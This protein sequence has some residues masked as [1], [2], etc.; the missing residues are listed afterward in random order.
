MS[1]WFED[2]SFWKA[3]YPFM[4]SERKFDGATDEVR[5]I[6]DLASLDRGDVLDLAC[7]PGRHAV[8]L[9][10]EGFN[11]TGVDLSPF[12]LQKAMGLAQ[13]EDVDV[14][15]VLEDMRR[16]VRPE[17]F[18]LVTSI[19]TSFG[20]FDDKREDMI[21]LQNIHRS[22]REGG[23]LVM[24]LMGK[25]WLARGFLPTSSEELADGRLLVE[26]REIT[27]D[28]TRVKNQWTVIEGDRATTFRFEHTVYSGQE[29]RDRL[30][31]AGFSDVQLFGG[32]D[33]REYGLNAHRLVA[34]ARKAMKRRFL[35]G[36][37]WT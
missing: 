3:L 15:W 26:R 1:E 36:Q 34:V 35:F 10:R 31:D 8:A 23:A 14:E 13:E 27:D 25:E 17:A 20:Y 12:L 37:P 4:F 9:A 18:D 6:L 16:F 33:G 7:G 21:V 32:L 5:G 24:E 30:L 11:V 2:D 19:F 28:W 22:L 29:M